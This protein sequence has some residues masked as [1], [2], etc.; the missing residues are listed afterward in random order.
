MSWKATCLD[1]ASMEGFFG[2]MKDEFYRHRAFDSFD[3]FKEQIDAYIAY[4]N[5]RRYQARLKGMAPV[6]CT[7]SHFLDTRNGR[8]LYAIRP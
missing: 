6:Q 2:H 3:S 1:N 7:A 8:L 5:T 4:W